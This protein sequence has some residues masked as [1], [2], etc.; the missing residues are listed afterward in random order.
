MRWGQIDRI[1]AVPA[2]RIKAK[3]EQRL[4]IFES[5]GIQSAIVHGFV[6]SF[7]Y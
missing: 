2:G 1:W 4:P 6:F 3:R 5:D 7:R